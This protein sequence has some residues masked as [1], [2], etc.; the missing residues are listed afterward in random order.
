MFETVCITIIISIYTDH[1]NL[2]EI[3]LNWD[4]GP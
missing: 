3:F 1:K 4:E 2:P